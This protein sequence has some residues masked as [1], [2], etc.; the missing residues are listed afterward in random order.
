MPTL[1]QACRYVLFVVV[2]IRCFRQT[3][4]GRQAEGGEEEKVRLSNKQRVNILS[5]IQIRN[6]KGPKIAP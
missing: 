5:L 4:A 3:R 1:P 6:N 2:P